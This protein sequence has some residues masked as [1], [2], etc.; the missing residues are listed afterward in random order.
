MPI[1]NGKIAREST[2][3]TRQQTP[4]NQELTT[5]TD[6]DTPHFIVSTRQAKPGNQL[7]TITTDRYNQQ[8]TT[9]NRHAF[10]NRNN[11]H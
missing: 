11:Y 5:T 9:D 7:Q 1:P 8:P 2:A 10:D 6:S 3:N 4:V